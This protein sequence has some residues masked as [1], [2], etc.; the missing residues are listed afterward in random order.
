MLIFL[1]SNVPPSLEDGIKSV[2]QCVFCSILILWDLWLIQRSPQS[3]HFGDTRTN[4][5]KLFSQSIKC[6]CIHISPGKIW[7]YGIPQNWSW[8]PYFSFIYPVGLK[9]LRRVFETLTSNISCSHVSHDS[10]VFHLLHQFRESLW[11]VTQKN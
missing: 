5:V 6:D 2:C 9:F 10:H 4:K 11:C 1:A 8:A 3:I 7:S